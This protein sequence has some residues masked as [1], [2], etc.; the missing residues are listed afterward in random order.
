MGKNLLKISVLTAAMAGMLSLTGCGTVATM[1]QEEITAASIQA[2]TYDKSHS[3]AWNITKVMG[4]EHN[5]K[6]AYLDETE[7]NQAQTNS[8]IEWYVGG[9]LL[10]GNPFDLGAM[11]FLFTP[12]PTNIIENPV[13]L[14]YF[15]KDKA[16]DERTAFTAFERQ[17][18]DAYEAAAVEMDFKKTDYKLALSFERPETS[19]SITVK[20]ILGDGKTLKLAHEANIPEWISSQKEATWAVG[21]SPS[22]QLGM[23]TLRVLDGGIFESGKSSKLQSELMERVAKHLPDHAFM[24]VPSMRN[25]N[26]DRTPA[27]V[28]DNKQKYFFVMPKSAQPK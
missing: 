16:T 18:L 6:D 9:T 10:T 17:V 7:Y 15:P 19:G 23:D 14:G 25:E 22:P 3:F 28:T 26:G 11:L 13:Y 27:Y 21:A 4:L 5:F 8:K 24:F 2:S 20:M 1:S 12:S